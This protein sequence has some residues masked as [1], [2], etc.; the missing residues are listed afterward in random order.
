MKKITPNLWFDMN[1]E[2]AAE[3][4]V[5]LFPDSHIDRV[6]RSPAEN[7]S[8]GK[9][10]V[11]TVEFTL[12]GQPFVG[13]NGGPR[14]SFTEAVSFNIDCE[15]QAEIDYYWN[16][17]TSDG[18]SAGRCGWCKDRFGLS[19]QVTPT[20]L[21]D[22][23]KSPDREAAGRAMQAMLLLDKMD[24]ATLERAYRGEECA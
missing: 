4:Y 9:G 1:A 20:S 6:V 14:Y 7:P 17:L 19:W 5:D 23:I 21:G 12:L 13:I 15:D 16:V 10:E 22:M 8:T 24:I 11:V 2:E 3:F 18:G